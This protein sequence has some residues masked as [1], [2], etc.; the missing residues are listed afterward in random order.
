MSVQERHASELLTLEGVVGTG[1]GLDAEGDPVIEVYTESLGPP[2]LPETLEGVPV[3]PLITGPIVAQTTKDRIRPVPPGVSVGHPA[4]TAGTLGAIVADSGGHTYI[5]SN[6]HVLANGNAGSIGDA[7]LQ[8]GPFDGGVDP[9]DRFGTLAA[10]V[11]INFCTTLDDSCSSNTVDA[12]I[13][14]V[15]ADDVVTRTYCGWT[16]TSAQVDPELGL[17]VHKCGRTT[18]ETVGTISAINVQIS[19]CYESAPGGCVQWAVF[20]GQFRV[21]SVSFSGPGDSGSLIATQGDNSPVGL[22]FAGSFTST[23]A[24]PIADVLSALSVTIVGS[25]S[26]PPETV[27][28]AGPDDPSRVPSAT[29]EF[30]SSESGGSFECALDGDPFAACT[31]PHDYT[32]LIDGA[33]AFQ[34]RAR[35]SAG[36]ADATPAV[37]TWTIDT[38]PP[39]TTVTS[40]PSDSPSPGSASFEFVS[41]E[42]GGGFECALDGEAFAECTSPVTYVDLAVGLHVFQ[43]RAKDEAGNVDATPDRREWSV[44]PPAPLL[45]FSIAPGGTV[46]GL[47]VENADIVAFDGTTFTLRLDGSEAAIDGFEVDAIAFASDTEVLLSFA[48]PA[49]VPEVGAVDDSDVV[50]FTAASPGS[51]TGSLDLYLDGS[52]VGLSTSAE[53]VDALELL[54]DGHLLVSTR[55]S[56]AVDAVLGDDEDLIE[57]TPV[58][59]GPTSAGTWAMYF[60]GSDVGLADGGE[61]VD[62]V[63]VDLNGDLYLS[64]AAGF[65]VSGASGAD[66][67]V[68]AF[69]PDSLGSDTAGSYASTTFFDGSAHGLG[70]TDV[71]AIELTR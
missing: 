16:A 35:D 11:P 70:E 56:F 32:D 26:T 15:E 3:D 69:T 30:A 38:T 33:H 22:L 61:D 9:A 60:D 67:D 19:V 41:S 12:A 13:A 52:D 2:E 21:S 39:E 54:P 55:G 5:L 63:A 45:S 58:A 37:W 64:T 57:L 31:S 40:G 7:A 6:N 50:R 65:S 23:F 49:T 46:G 24:N 10:F 29:F 66:E 14:R 25:D 53:D 28:A 17:P 18:E 71:V 4:I 43:V 47:A 20:D 8:P 36:N 59:L 44:D 27:I 1:L 51:S 42:N 34:V 48:S 62:G 68:T